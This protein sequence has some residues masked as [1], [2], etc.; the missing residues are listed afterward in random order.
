MNSEAIIDADA[1]V[2]SALL[3][4]RPGEVQTSK[5]RHSEMFCGLSGA[6]PLD[7]GR[8]GSAMDGTCLFS[9]CVPD[10]DDVRRAR[11]CGVRRPCALCALRAL[12]ALCV[13]CTLWVRLVCA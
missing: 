2:A 3:R 11:P 12:R 4:Y 5:T 1:S 10:V 7:H 6:T 9:Q 13:L 8:A